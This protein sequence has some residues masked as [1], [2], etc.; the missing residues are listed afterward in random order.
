[1]A[2]VA[3]SKFPHPTNKNIFKISRIV[4]MPHWQSYGIG[5]KMVEHIAENFYSENDLRLTTTLPIIHEY[6]WKNS[7]WA[8]K[9]Q[10]IR[11]NSEAG[12]N[13]KMAN[14]VRECY[15]ETYQYKNNQ[16][17]DLKVLRTGCPPDKI[18][19]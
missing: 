7:K 16:I 17:K 8:L 3:F 6:L 9:F 11:K 19:Q 18:R 13:A 12:K 2:F 1:M 4:V 14:D 15:L 5:M 10:G